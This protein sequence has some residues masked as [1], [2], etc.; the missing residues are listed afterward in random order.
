MCVCAPGPPQDA[1]LDAPP[2]IGPDPQAALHR[3][4]LSAAPAPKVRARHHPSLKNHPTDQRVRHVYL[5][6]IVRQN[7]QCAWVR[8]REPFANDQP[9]PAQRSNPDVCDAS[10]P[11]LRTQVVLGPLPQPRDR[12]GAC[13]DPAG[14]D[15]KR[16]CT[17]LPGD[18]GGKRVA[19]A[20]GG[21]AC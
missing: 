12:A 2:R 15:T 11:P 3:G 16:L 4:L 20:V 14:L 5:G 6:W 10:W 18:E 7:V 13:Q 19:V 17:T 8:T 21:A 9:I 1:V